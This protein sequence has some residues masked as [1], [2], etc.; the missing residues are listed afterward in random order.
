MEK[1]SNP[2]LVVQSNQ[3]INLRHTLSLAEAR[4]FLS[5]VAQIERDDDDF[6]T[7]RIDVKDFS[8]MVGLKGQSSY[9]ALKEVAESLRYKEFKTVRADGGWLVMGYISS[10]E[11]LPGQGV[12]ELSFD[13]KLKPYL[14]NLKEAFTQYDIRYIISLR[15]IHSVRI[16]ELLKQYERIRVREFDLQELKYKLNIDE[17]YKRYTDFKTNVLEIAR[18]DLQ[19]TTDIWFE[20]EEIKQGR[21]IKRIKFHIFSKSSP[22]GEVSIDGPVLPLP[23]VAFQPVVIVAALNPELLLLFQSFEPGLSEETVSQFMDGV[24]ATQE[25][26]LDVLHY[27]R[28]EQ[29]KGTPIRNILAY[30]RKGLAASLGQGLHQQ[31]QA[32]KQQAAGQKR[33]AQAHR[34]V[35]RWYEE[36]FSVYLSGY[37][38]QRG[39]E[40]AV[41]VKNRFLKYIDQQ[42]LASPGLRSLYYGPD[43][44]PNQ[45]QFRLGLGKALSE[46]AGERE[47]VLFIAWCREHKAV[48]IERVANQWRIV[49][50]TTSSSNQGLDDE[51]EPF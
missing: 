13:P 6:K 20:Y 51:I 50:D 17:K 44:K 39:K 14:L 10:A 36:E 1:K 47:E 3:F 42:V 48:V 34:E 19:K 2:H 31:A 15:S 33:Q 32:R 7:Y 26:V 22:V 38:I 11:Y 43:G 5:M 24:E 25:Q 16:Y 40:A 35:S 49:D 21:V 29:Q 4:V 18:R 27:A 41:A 28:Q 37:Y 23:A 45:E 9:S 30:V 8:D 12:V 46:E